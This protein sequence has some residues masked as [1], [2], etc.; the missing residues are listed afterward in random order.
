MKLLPK[1]QLAIDKLSRFKA[2]ALFMDMGEGKTRS[3]IEIAN[4]AHGNYDYIIW[5]APASLVNNPNYKDEIFK[6]KPKK[7]VKFWT[8]E[9][10]GSSDKQFLEMRNFAKEHRVFC[11]IDE[12][13]K[14]KNA[15][16]KVTKRLISN[17]RIFDYRFILNGTPV[18]KSLIDLWSQM[19]FLHPKIL[20]MTES[21]FAYKFLEFIEDGARPWKRWSKPHNEA[22]L[23]KMIE[24]YV[25]DSKLDIPSN[26]II[27]QSFFNLN[28]KERSIYSSKKHDFFKKLEEENENE[29]ENKDVT[30][31]AL[32]QYCQSIYTACSAKVDYVANI[33]QPCIFFVKYLHEV[34]LLLDKIPNS[35]EY[36]GKVKSDLS[37]ATKNKSSIIMTY[38]TG[39]NGLNLQMYNNI[40]FFSQT[41]DWGQ[42]EQALHRIYRTGQQNDIN[43]YDFYVDTGLDK[44]IKK[45]LDKK[46]KLVTKLK[47]ITNKSKKELLDLL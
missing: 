7:E 3:I 11:I 29:N 42:K 18:T 1:Q 15:G 24:P 41:F 8:I 22:L 5:I 31:L 17:Y 36:S 44:M 32:A 37:Q 33:K 34:G 38:G 27:K 6:W 43:V 30:F 25:F 19:E 20:D 4:L 9:S 23:M 46:G 16:A 39:A 10:I 14:I 13:L 28:Q 2:G 35:V 45:S 12:S 26:K 21:Q 40:C 47:S